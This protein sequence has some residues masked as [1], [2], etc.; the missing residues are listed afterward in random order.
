[1]KESIQ[2]INL[3][4]IFDKSD[5]DSI[6][7]IR[8]YL[9]KKYL[10]SFDFGT[11]SEVKDSMEY[12][13]QVD[14]AQGLLF[15]KGNTVTG[16]SMI[17]SNVSFSKID[18]LSPKAV[19]I[20]TRSKCEAILTKTISSDGDASFFILPIELIDAWEPQRIE[21]PKGSLDSLLS[22]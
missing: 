13:I 4:K 11:N 20:I 22:K 3:C 16:Y 14:W 2:T 19:P 12:V 6:A 15:Y 18:A 21:Y 8:P 17:S 5:W 9:P 1:M 7:V 10:R